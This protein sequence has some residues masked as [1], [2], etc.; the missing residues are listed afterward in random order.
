MW[1][2]SIKKRKGF[3]LIEIL[4]VIGILGILFAV[5]S[6]PIMSLYRKIIFQGAVEN[7]ITMLDE[8]R[9]STL[10]SYYSSQYGVHI[11]SSTVTLFRGSSYSVSDPNNDVY[12]LSNAVKI[13]EINITGGGDDVIFE[14]ITGETAQ[15]GNIVLTPL[16][17]TLSSSTIVVYKSGLVE[18]SN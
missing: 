3:T 11:A 16:V 1:T 13:T 9:K 8:A 12:E 4:A 6:S 18:I 7:V 10:S 14:R 15:D 5:I 17:G 2:A